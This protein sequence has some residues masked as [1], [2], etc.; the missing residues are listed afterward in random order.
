MINL[1]AVLHRRLDQAGLAE[2]F[3]QYGLQVSDSKIALTDNYALLKQLN[4]EHAAAEQLRRSLL[5]KND[6][7]P[8]LWYLL[9]KTALQ[10]RRPADAVNYLRKAITRAP[11]MHQLYLEL[12]VAHY[13]N[14]QFGYAKRTLEKAA[15]LANGRDTQQRY[16]AKLEAIKLS[17]D[18]N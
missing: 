7:D 1:T 18:T 12:A 14:N 15:E 11:Y 3:Y 2:Q 13:Q 4:G 10:Q 16:F 6:A 5:A 17:A 9:G 8:Y